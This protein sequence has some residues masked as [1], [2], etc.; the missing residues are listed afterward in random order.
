[1]RKAAGGGG[2]A[3]AAA[4]GARPAM[5][6]FV[7]TIKAGAMGITLTAASAVFLMEP[8]IDPS[9]EIQ[10]AGRIHR[11][12]Q[13][14]DVLVHRMVVKYTIEEQIVKAHEKL[15]SGAA[16]LSGSMWP[17][18][19]VRSVFKHEKQHGDGGEE[20]ARTARIARVKRER[21]QAQ[22]DAQRRHEQAKAKES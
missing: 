10:A 15:R 7:I 8:A 20:A 19:L 17:A 12:G 3:A 2:S 1:M 6:V 5:K 9:L 18:G 16:A 21:E 13:T 4:S 11:L 14:K 22:A